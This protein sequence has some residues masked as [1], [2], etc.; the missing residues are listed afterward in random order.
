MMD[1][2][3]RWRGRGRWVSWCGS[4]EGCDRVVLSQSASETQAR[5]DGFTA[6]V[7]GRLRHSNA[8]VC[9]APGGYIHVTRTKGIN[10]KILS[11]HL[12]ACSVCEK[13]P[14]STRTHTGC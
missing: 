14:Q 12:V 2:E 7:G 5:L 10:S 9:D 8:T 6:E 3:W 13:N 4:R 11:D 1:T